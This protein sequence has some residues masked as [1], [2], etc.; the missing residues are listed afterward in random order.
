MLSDIKLKKIETIYSKKM[1]K[2]PIGIICDH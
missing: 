1:Q 2:I